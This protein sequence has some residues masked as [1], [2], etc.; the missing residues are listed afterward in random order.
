MR[1]ASYISLRAPTNVCP[2]RRARS[3]GLA[4]GLAGE[5]EGKE[6]TTQVCP[7]A[8]AIVIA[9]PTSTRPARSRLTGQRPPIAPNRVRPKKHTDVPASSGTP[10]PTPQ[11]DH[12][13]PALALAR[14]LATNS[15]LAHRMG[16][17]GR[18]QK[19][20]PTTT[21]CAAAPPRIAL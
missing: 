20:R 6:H 10:E 15:P 4:L 13:N 11:M 3:R 9:A 19:T 7:F 18:R 1:S 12:T 5:G 2:R 16:T 8:I 17:G 14:A 21:L